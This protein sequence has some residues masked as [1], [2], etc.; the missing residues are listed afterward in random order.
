M[1]IYK[2]L[3]LTACLVAGSLGLLGCSGCAKD[4]TRLESVEQA[5][6]VVINQETIDP[7]NNEI[8]TIK[9]ESLEFDQSLEGPYEVIGIVDGDTYDVLIDRKP[10]RIRMEGIDAPERGMPF[11]KKSNRYLGSLIFR[12]KVEISKSKGKTWDREVH[13]TYLNGVDISMEML[14]AGMA[15][16]YKE[17][18][19]EELYAK[20]E[21]NAKEQ[22]LGLWRDKNPVEPWTIRKLH[23]QG[24]STKPLFKNKI[25]D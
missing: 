1:K 9:E 14:S 11:Y 3:V 23:R 13:S 21:Q 24:I 8:D 2:L 15:W 18:S 16:H 10:V 5:K 4:S 19:S 17:F 25:V 6:P 22:G 20:V 12:K 7:L